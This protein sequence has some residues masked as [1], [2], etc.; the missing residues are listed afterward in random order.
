MPPLVKQRSLPPHLQ[1]IS[2]L[3]IHPLEMLFAHLP[4]SLEMSKSTGFLAFTF[5]VLLRLEPHSHLRVL[6]GP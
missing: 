4:V 6:Q 1:H 3:C 2:E 5:A